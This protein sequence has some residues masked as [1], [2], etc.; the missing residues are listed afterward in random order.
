M[1]GIIQIFFN[2]IFLKERQII[3][4]KQEKN[5]NSATFLEKCRIMPTQKNNAQ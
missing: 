3:T 5:A 4:E 2:I 1:A